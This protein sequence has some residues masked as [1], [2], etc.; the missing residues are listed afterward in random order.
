MIQL[1]KKY[2]FNKCGKILGANKLNHTLLHYFII[3][4]EIKERKLLTIYVTSSKVK[5]KIPG[6]GKIFLK[7]VNCQCISKCSIFYS[8]F[9]IR[10]KM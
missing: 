4:R 1:Q 6:T 8:E 10:T 9:V 5:I 7:V 2:M 3:Q